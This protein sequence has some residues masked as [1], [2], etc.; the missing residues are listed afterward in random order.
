ML[1]K[2]RLYQS[3]PRKKVFL[4]TACPLF[5]LR[6]REFSD[7]PLNFRNRAKLEVDLVFFTIAAGIILAI[8]MLET[9][10]RIRLTLPISAS[11]PNPNR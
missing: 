3:I 10:G 4:Q 6:R 2:V 9:R 5:F 8:R 11:A 1:A 7:S